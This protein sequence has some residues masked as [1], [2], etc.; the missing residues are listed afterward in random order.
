[1][2]P[3]GAYAHSLGLEG[4][5]Q[6]GLVNDV[7]SYA[8]YVANFAVPQMIHVELPSVGF[9]FDASMAEDLDT[10]SRLDREYGAL[11]ATRELRQA[12]YNIGSQRLA[13]L[14]G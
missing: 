11:K 1:M 12:S 8:A 3:S 4:A 14:D 13:L 2:F 7:E 6:E 9:A 5:V 10:F